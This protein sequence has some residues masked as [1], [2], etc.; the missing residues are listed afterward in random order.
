MTGIKNN[1]IDLSNR[2]CGATDHAMSE[3]KNETNVIDEKIHKVS[4]IMIHYLIDD[5]LNEIITPSRKKL[6]KIVV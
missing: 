6:S 1:K 4:E 2:I 5:E 3:I